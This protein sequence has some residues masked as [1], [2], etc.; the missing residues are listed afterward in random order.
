MASTTAAMSCPKIMQ[1]PSSGSSTQGATSG[2]GVTAASAAAKE[3]ENTAVLQNKGA[4]SPAAVMLVKEEKKEDNAVLLVRPGGKPISA[5]DENA[6]TEDAS[7]TTDHAFSQDDAAPCHMNTQAAWDPLEEIDSALLSALCDTRERKALYRLEQVILDFMKDKSSRFMEV[8]GA[9]NSIVLGQN[10]RGASSDGETP[11]VQAFSNQG[12]LDLQYQQQRG[13]RQTSFQRLILHR[14]A[15][16]FDV[17]REQINNTNNSGCDE[18]SLVDVGLNPCRSPSF[19]PGLIRLVKTSESFIPPYL[20]IDIDL[21]LL[22]DYKNPRAR[23]FSGGNTKANIPNAHSNNYEDA[24]KNLSENM[25]SSILEDPLSANGNKKSKKKL[26]IMKRNS[27]SESRD[28]IGGKGKGKHTGSSRRKKLEDREKAYEEARARIFGAHEVSG[29]HA[30]DGSDENTEKGE[31]SSVPQRSDPQDH[32]LASLHSCHSPV[33]AQDDAIAPTGFPSRE[34]IIP[35]QVMSAI[36]PPD[37][38][39]PPSPELQGETECSSVPAAVT[40]GAIFKAVYRNRQQEENDPDFKRTSD[41]RP[42]YVPYVANPYGAPVGYVNPAMGQQHS[43]Q[44]MAMQLQQAHQSHFYHG[45]HTT[46]QVPIAQ[47]AAAYASNIGNNQST[48]WPPTPSR[49]YCP[50]PQ[51]E[52]KQEEH[53]QAWHSHSQ[54][55]RS[56]QVQ[57]STASSSNSGNVYNATTRLQSKQPTTVLWGPRTQGNGC[58]LEELVSSSPE[59]VPR[60]GREEKSALQIGE[61][62][63]ALSSP[64]VVV[65]QGSSPQE[66]AGRSL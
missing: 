4:F 19:S 15:D 64:P 30:N 16:R 44:I 29:N 20:L 65:R 47:D 49:G 6:P 36:P 61:D 11:D 45:L 24:A 28:S 18:G 27:T 33:S 41:I 43:A 63:P 59:G 34:R 55:N 21:D 13:L 42:A 2:C 58:E 10:C 26:V 31:R 12:F 52:G 3:K 9:F 48:Q 60:T 66:P 40:S 14:L 53:P 51:Q 35:S 39:S 37:H 8:G 62:F 46:T 22:V 54:N 56:T 32:A 7:R 50:Q 23:N 1:R 25:T 5:I 17:L 38:V 57:P